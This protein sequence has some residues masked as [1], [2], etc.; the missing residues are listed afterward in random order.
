VATRCHAD[1][2]EPLSAVID[3]RPRAPGRSSVSRRWKRG[4]EPTLAE[5]M[6]L[7]LCGLEV[8]LLSTFRSTASSWVFLDKLSV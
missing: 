6:A 4:T 5:L 7:D 3:D 2:S 1:V 8:A